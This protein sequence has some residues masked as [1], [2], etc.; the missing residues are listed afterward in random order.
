MR[1]SRYR[2]QVQFYRVFNRLN[3]HPCRNM[4]TAARRYY[5]MVGAARF[6]G[7]A[8]RHRLISFCGGPKPQDEE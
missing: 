2:Q 4:A 5:G 7:Y 8:S 6:S 3:R 1:L